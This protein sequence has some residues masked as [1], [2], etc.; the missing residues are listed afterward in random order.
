MQLHDPSARLVTPFKNFEDP[1]VSLNSSENR[2]PT[3]DDV[4][5]SKCHTHTLEQIEMFL[6][7]QPI[8]NKFVYA[9][10]TYI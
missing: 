9:D 2:H 4:C 1:L 6:K 8:E 7:V 5:A 3:E 10:Y